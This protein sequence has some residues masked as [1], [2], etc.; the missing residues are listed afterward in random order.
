MR[1]REER[2]CTGGRERGDML[3]LVI[4]CCAVGAVGGTVS[5]AL[6]PQVM[7]SELELRRNKHNATSQPSLSKDA[8]VSKNGIG[9]EC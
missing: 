7:R 6:T 1:E 5:A 3:F 8:D 9:A 2:E 4:L